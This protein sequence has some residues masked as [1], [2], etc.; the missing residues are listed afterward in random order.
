MDRWSYR[1]LKQTLK[2]F[3]ECAWPWFVFPFVVL[4]LD[5]PF[6]F[7]GNFQVNDALISEWSVLGSFSQ[8]PESTILNPPSPKQN[9]TRKHNVTSS[10]KQTL[11]IKIPRTT[12]VF[13]QKSRKFSFSWCAL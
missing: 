1:P 9:F 6:C 13:H 3:G 12:A 2:G 5:A 11:A 8:S 10:S 7:G 4:I